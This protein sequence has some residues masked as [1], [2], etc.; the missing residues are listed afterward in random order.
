[1]N[2]VF[3]SVFSQLF[4]FTSSGYTTMNTLLVSVFYQLFIFTPCGNITLQLW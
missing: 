1:M 4:I 2:T 3:V